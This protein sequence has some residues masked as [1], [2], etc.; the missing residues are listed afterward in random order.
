MGNVSWLIP[1]IHPALGLGGAPDVLPHNAAFAASTVEPAACDALVDGASA[2]AGLAADYLV[3]AELREAALAEF[4]QRG[5][6]RR[7]E[8]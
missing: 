3:D 2:L 4:E 5:G 8:R 7:W 6:R 1:A